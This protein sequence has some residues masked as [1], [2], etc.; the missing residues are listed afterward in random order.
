MRKTLFHPGL[1]VYLRS[2]EMLLAFIGY[3]ILVSTVLQRTCDERVSSAGPWVDRVDLAAII[4]KKNTRIIRS[5]GLEKV[6]E[7]ST[8]I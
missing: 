6:H 8:L 5:F 4:L 3:E 2:V 7:I 1:C